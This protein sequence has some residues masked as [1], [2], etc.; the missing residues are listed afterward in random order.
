MSRSRIILVGTIS[1]CLALGPA[2]RRLDQASG[3]EHLSL[4]SEIVAQLDA[5]A[6]EVITSHG[7]P[8]LAVAVAMGD[9]VVFERGYG[10]TS[11]SDGPRVDSKTIFRVG[12]VTKEFTAAVIMRLLEGDRL[13]LN[14]PITRFPT[15]SLS[16]YVIFDR[17]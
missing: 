7:T 15:G 10:L 11:I 12:S 14:D 16:A 2:C 8:G 4:P 17:H 13:S 9:R 3:S 6:R 1:V 5:T